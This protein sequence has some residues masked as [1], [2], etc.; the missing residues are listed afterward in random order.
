MQGIIASAQTCTLACQISACKNGKHAHKLQ[1]AQH[2]KLFASAVAASAL[3]N[4][5]A[6][7]P[8]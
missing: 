2:R 4:V 1:I 3:A 6:T 7:D 5:V 8:N